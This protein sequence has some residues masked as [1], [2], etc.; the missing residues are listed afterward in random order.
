MPINCRSEFASPACPQ[1]LMPRNLLPDRQVNPTPTESTFVF[2][3][4]KAGSNFYRV[5][6]CSSG[7]NLLSITSCPKCPFAPVTAIIVSFQNREEIAC[8]LGWL[9]FT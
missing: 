3:S 6:E 1:S 2:E 7:Y 8:R 9:L 5:P 4:G